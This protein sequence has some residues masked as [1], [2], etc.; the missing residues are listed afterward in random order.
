MSMRPILE[1][2]ANFNQNIASFD[3]L[4]DVR[5]DNANSHTFL[6]LARPRCQE[7][8]LKTAFAS[9]FL[10]HQPCGTAPIVLDESS[11]F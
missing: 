7:G 11:R 3:S 2:A 9:A 5:A 6:A 4:H 10:E 8:K 1:W